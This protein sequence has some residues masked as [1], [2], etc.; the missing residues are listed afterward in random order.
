MQTFPN[1]TIFKEME[2][3]TLLDILV[4]DL[5]CNKSDDE[6]RLHIN[7]LIRHDNCSLSTITSAIANSQINEYIDLELFSYCINRIV[8][9][10]QVQDYL[11]II[12]DYVSDI[13]RKDRAENIEEFVVG[14]IVD[15]NGYKRL[16]GRQLWDYL[17]LNNSDIN[18]LLM[19][20]E[21]QG[22]FVISMMQDLGN[23]EKRLKKTIL[24]FNSEFPTVRK[25]LVT[26]LKEY[27]LNYCGTVSRQIKEVVLNQSEEHEE[28]LNFLHSIDNRYAYMNKCKELD[29]NYSMPLVLEWCNRSIRKNMKEAIKDAESKQDSFIDKYM[30][31]VVLGKG[32]GWRDKDG[33]VQGLAHIK[34][35]REMPIMINSM[36]PLENLDWYN[37]ILLDWNIMVKKNEE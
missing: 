2:D 29:S 16:I 35:S 24:F 22:R 19:P 9:S 26:I 6:I 25:I 7:K 34:F 3:K 36:S 20:E 23:P 28:F 27:A 14:L 17:N 5:A 10:K 30:T 12:K 31:T 11:D 15:T 8:E 4:E 32:G 37:K 1:Y 13:L 18:L 21:F 33:N